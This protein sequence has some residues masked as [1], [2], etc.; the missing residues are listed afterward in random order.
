MQGTPPGLLSG[1]PCLLKRAQQNTLS[2][3]CSLLPCAPLGNFLIFLWHFSST[4]RQQQA[5]VPWD[6]QRGR[7]F[8]TR[9]FP[10]C[11]SS[12]LPPYR[13]HR[14]A[15][16]TSS[17]MDTFKFPGSSCLELAKGNAIKGFVVFVK[18]MSFHATVFKKS[19]IRWLAAFSAFFANPFPCQAA[20]LP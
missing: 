15:S 3:L 13:T 4:Q 19:A 5:Q 11:R 9:P 1:T 14:A 12:F 8:S 20:N 7:G 6:Q 2:C 17:L 18:K 10:S 16:S